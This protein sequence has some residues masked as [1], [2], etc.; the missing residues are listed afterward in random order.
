MFFLLPFYLLLPDS[1]LPRLL[2]LPQWHLPLLSTP[3]TQRFDRSFFLIHYL[4]SVAFVFSIFKN[5]LR[6]W[7]Y[8]GATA[9]FFFLTSGVKMR[10]CRS[11]SDCNTCPG[12]IVNQSRFTVSNYFKIVHRNRSKSIVALTSG[13]TPI[14]SVFFTKSW[15][16]YC[17]ICFLIEF[18]HDFVMQNLQKQLQ[19]DPASLPFDEVCT[20][21]DLAFVPCLSTCISFNNDNFLVCLCLTFFI[22]VIIPDSL[23]QYRQPTISWAATYYVF[24]RGWLRLNILDFYLL[25]HIFFDL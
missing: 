3:S 7:W 16:F 13:S 8:H 20:V 6:P 12:I 1:I 19:T 2:L 11:W 25:N 5:F 17:L 14:Q 23:L 18:G 24:Q 21:I 22:H 9:C 4:R 10:V 15:W